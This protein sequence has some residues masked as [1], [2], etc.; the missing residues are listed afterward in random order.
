MDYNITSQTPDDA[1]AQLSRLGLDPV[2]LEQ[3]NVLVLRDM[4]YCHAGP[5]IQGKTS[6]EHDE[7]C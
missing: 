3:E 4:V 1:R 2:Q 6:L 7:S 5:A